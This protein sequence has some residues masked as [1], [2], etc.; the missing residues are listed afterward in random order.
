MAGI[1]RSVYLRSTE[2]VYL[3]DVFAEGR[4]N[5]DLT[6]GKLQVQVRGGFESISETGWKVEAQLLDPSGVKV[7]SIHIKEKSLLQKKR[8][9]ISAI[10]I[11][12]LYQCQTLSVG[13]QK[14][15]KGIPC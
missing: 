12:F 4:L 15:L 2:K 13:L 9:S 11:V 7:K 6:E 8:E 3:E 5:C 14:L 10:C 1:H